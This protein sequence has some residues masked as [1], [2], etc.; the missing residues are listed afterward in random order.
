MGEFIDK[1][2]G[3]ANQ[4]I[5]KAKVA[6]GQRTDNPDLIINGAKQQAK[7]EVQKVVGAAKGVL[8]DKL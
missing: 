3:A 5:G 6:V 2:K 8:G 4:A 1:A 7:G